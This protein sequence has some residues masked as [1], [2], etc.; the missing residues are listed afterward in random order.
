MDYQV[1][2]FIRIYSECADLISEVLKDIPTDQ[3]IWK[4][5]AESRSIAEISRHILRV[6]DILLKKINIEPK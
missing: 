3:L 2:Y 1:P 6:D 5:G 4:P